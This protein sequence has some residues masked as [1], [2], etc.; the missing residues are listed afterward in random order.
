MSLG[1][2][3][4][5][6]VFTAACIFTVYALVVIHWLMTVPY[7]K[8]EPWWVRLLARLLRAGGRD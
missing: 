5:S 7:S 6:L 8:D 2:W 1:E 3:I 4:S